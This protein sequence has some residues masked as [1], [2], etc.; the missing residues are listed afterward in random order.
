MSKV[1]FINIIRS[2]F[3]GVF[4]GICFNLY[5]SSHY[6]FTE[7]FY[8]ALISGLIG[9]VIGGITEVATAFLPISIAKPRV[10]FSIN[11]LIAIVVAAIVFLLINHFWGTNGI[12]KD[13]I[14]TI[15]IIIM[16]MTL[17]NILDYVMYKKAN[18]KLKIFKERI[19]K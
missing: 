10:Y 4:I 19:E 14:V 7:W 18:K 9:L 3:L 5:I 11:G 17:A 1:N 8:F 12:T 6:T 2:S 16:I 13:E 15:V